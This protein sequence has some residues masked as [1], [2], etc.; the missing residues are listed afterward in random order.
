M[1]SIGVIFDEAKLL[2]DLQSITKSVQDLTTP[3]K[4]VGEYLTNQTRDRFDSQTAPDGTPWQPLSANYKAR[5]KRNQ[6]RILTL[7]AILRRSIHYR[8]QRREVVVGTDRIYG[9]VHQM[10]FSGIVD[11]RAF[12]RE[13]K[14]NDV[15]ANADGKRRKIASGV[16]FVRAHTRFMRMP[17]RPYIGLSNQDYNEIPRIFTRWLETR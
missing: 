8:A 16:G 6:D 1:A 9:A 12:R 4:A 2:R 7:S 14:R 13:N 10:G 15:Y 5:K 3:M 17:A 11:V